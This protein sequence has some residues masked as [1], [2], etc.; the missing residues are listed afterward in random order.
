MRLA[1][2]LIKFKNLTAALTTS[3]RVEVLYYGNCIYC[4]SIFWTFSSERVT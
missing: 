2:A 1:T 4:N 3:P